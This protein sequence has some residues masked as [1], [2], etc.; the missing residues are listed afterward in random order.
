MKKKKKQDI[1]ETHE[2]LKGLEI[3][4]NEFG[5]LISNIPVEKL[6]DFLNHHVLDKKLHEHEWEE[7]KKKLPSSKSKAP[8]PSK[9]K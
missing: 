6:N 2:D 4:V 3:R 7:K 9:K 8:S 1:A 5:E